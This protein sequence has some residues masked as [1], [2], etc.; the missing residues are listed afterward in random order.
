M[1]TWDL[2]TVCWSGFQRLVRGVQRGYLFDGGGSCR[3]GVMQCVRSGYVQ[4]FSQPVLC[5]LCCRDILP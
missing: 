3:C 4:P 2:W 5:I 1:R